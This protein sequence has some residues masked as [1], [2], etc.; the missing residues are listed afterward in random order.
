MVC[1]LVC[2]FV[3]FG[4]DILTFSFALG[5]SFGKPTLFS[6]WLGISD[7]LGERPLDLAVGLDFV[8]G[9]KRRATC[10]DDTE[11][12]IRFFGTVFCDDFWKV[13]VAPSEHLLPV[14]R[15]LP[16][17]TASTLPWKVRGLSAVLRVPK[18]SRL[19]SKPE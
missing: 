17:G 6:A 14:D 19:R 3:G 7:G 2:F 15:E 18:H 1:L 4:T 10:G 16:T 8:V 12:V 13:T 9:S 5:G 11:D